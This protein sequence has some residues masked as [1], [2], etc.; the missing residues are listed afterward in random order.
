MFLFPCNPHPQLIPRRVQTWLAIFL[1]FF[2]IWSDPPPPRIKCNLAPL[3]LAGQTSCLIILPPHIPSH[4]QDVLTFLLCLALACIT[5][6]WIL[7]TT[8]RGRMLMLDTLALIIHGCFSPASLSGEE[9]CVSLKGFFSPLP[10][11]LPL[12]SW[13]W[14]VSCD[15]Q[16]RHLSSSLL[17]SLLFLLSL[18]SCD[19]SSVEGWLSANY[20]T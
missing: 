20:H 18:S 15:I 13:W 19:P 8:K 10:P 17:H 4:Q 1:L 6:A 7:M 12:Q 14:F 11:L 2:A 3:Q 9:L 16:S 5:P